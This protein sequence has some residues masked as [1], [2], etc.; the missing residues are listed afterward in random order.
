M[1]FQTETTVS[2]YAQ[3]LAKSN[4]DYS[5]NLG[6]GRWVLVF[7]FHCRLYW[8]RFPTTMV[9]P[10]TRGFNN[11]WSGFV[12]NQG[13]KVTCTQMLVRGGAAYLLKKHASR[14]FNRI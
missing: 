2:R 14:R 12:E 8:Y 13:I 10:L 4:V 9:T 6:D 11:K 3:I 7:K 5:N 1:R